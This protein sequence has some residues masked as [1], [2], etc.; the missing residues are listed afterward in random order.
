VP[1]SLPSFIATPYGPVRLDRIPLAVML[2]RD[3]K[4]SLAEAVWRRDPA[5]R[6]AAAFIAAMRRLFAPDPAHMIDT[7]AAEV[8]AWRIVDF[9]RHSFVLD[10]DDASNLCLG[11]IRQTPAR[12]T[13]EH[14]YAGVAAE[15]RPA[16]FRVT[17]AT[18]VYLRLMFPFHDGTGRVARVVTLI[19]PQAAPAAPGFVTH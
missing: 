14:T 13:A 10:G 19:R 4:A 7:T 15:R 12:L 3:G 17:M 6:R 16:C 8:A 5:L 11:E 18:R 2:V 1:Q 9:D